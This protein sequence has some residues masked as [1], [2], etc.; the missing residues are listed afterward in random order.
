M[1]VTS[2]WDETTGF[3]VPNSGSLAA[4]LTALP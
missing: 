1:P 2:G 4:Q 3:G